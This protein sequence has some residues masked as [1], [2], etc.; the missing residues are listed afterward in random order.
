M[1]R[2]DK[3]MN[4]QSPGT[5]TGRS[6]TSQRFFTKGLIF[7]MACPTVSFAIALYTPSPYKEWGLFGVFVSI[8]TLMLYRA[9][10]DSLGTSRATTSLPYT[11]ATFL[12]LVPFEGLAQ[13]R[14]KS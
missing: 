1:E 14:W 10:Q 13:M 2:G 7:S 8:S 5:T 4:E 6:T 9:I 11:I 3:R 12:A